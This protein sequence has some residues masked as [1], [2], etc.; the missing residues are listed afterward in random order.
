MRSSPP[1]GATPPRE[2]TSAEVR[3]A[4]ARHWLGG[5]QDAE[6]LGEVELRPHQRDAVCRLRALLVRYGGALLADAVGLGKTYVALALARE[7]ARPLVVAPASLR[8]MWEAAM[9]RTGVTAAW[10]SHEALSRS[11][12]GGTGDARGA[13]TGASRPDLVIVDEA[14]HA[15]NP[16]TRRYAALAARTRGARVLLL[17]ATPVHN[18]RADLV[19]LLALFLGARAERWSDAQLARCIVRREQGSRLLAASAS[20]A[21]GRL[22]RV[23]PPELLSIPCEIGVLEALLALPP[24]VPPADGGDGGALVVHGLVRRWASS[25]GALR[26]SLRRRAALAAALASSLEEGRHPTRQELRSWIAGEGTVQL[27][28]PGLLATPAAVERDVERLLAAVRE[29]ERALGRLLEALQRERDPDRAR[30]ERL[31][32][33]ARTRPG[34][35]IVA[36][37]AFAD[38]VRSLWRLLRATAGVAA[39]TS[40]GAV[41]VGGALTRA[42]ALA[43]FAPVAS[44][45]R[46]PVPAEHITLLLAT[47]LL[48]EGVNLQDASV[49]VHLDLPWTPARLEQRVG[50]IARLGSPHERIEV[51]AMMP[52]A[53]AESLIAVEH[54]LRD[55]LAVAHRSI[56]VAGS[57]VPSPFSRDADPSASDVAI[58]EQ[59]RATLTEWVIPGASGARDS[60]TP[61]VAAVRAATSGFLAALGAPSDP[62]ILGNAG[63]ST[64]DV[65]ATLLA[66]ARM[67]MGDDVAVDRAARDAALSAIARWCAGRRA[68][69]SVDLDGAAPARRRT[70]A[71]IAN[72]VGRARFHERVALSDLAADARRAAAARMGA[73]AERVLAELAE[74]PM[75][76]ETWLRAV[77]AFGREQAAEPEPDTPD[78]A[79]LVALI[80]LQPPA[81][82]R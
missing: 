9:R 69:A 70:L 13:G 46:A 35:K 54:R 57:I 6:A 61:I 2:R 52:P 41:V 1:P 24:P 78:A 82:S 10:L 48:S 60:A 8:P 11:S 49:V 37:S 65:P 19:A 63:G 62:I 7:A 79:G 71:R 18:R 34:A 21:I 32:A 23:P 4:I 81:S 51:F 17:S 27:A 22:P 12:A 68:A 56:G 43:R 67:A 74:A 30:A 53:P 66:A 38:T 72:I 3:A 75:S 39:L 31:L 59:L 45:T 76:D 77:A 73:G 80:L 15:R 14:H 55:K 33:L 44:G 20:G 29:H 25:R 40:R 5:R 16:R 47:D 50:R 36:F 26:S 42:E 58:R 64:S 28:L